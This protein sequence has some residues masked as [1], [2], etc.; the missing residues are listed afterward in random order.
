MIW[1]I[2]LGIVGYFFLRFFISLSKDKNDL[3]NQSLEEKFSGII[4]L[5]NNEA[6]DG[7]GS[8]SK[9]NEREINLYKEEANQIIKF[10]YSTGSLTITWKYKYFQKEVVHKRYYDQVR[11]I[12]LFEQMDIGNSII[13]EMRKVVND[14]KFK[15]IGI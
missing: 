6:Y 12:S 9:L 3:S 4:S 5:I 8:V 13:E 10:E 2:I 14:H 11:N 1:T 7:H 15:T